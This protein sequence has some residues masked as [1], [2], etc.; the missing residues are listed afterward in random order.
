MRSIEFKSPLLAFTVPGLILVAVAVGLAFFI[1]QAYSVVG[2]VVLGPTLLMLLLAVVGTFL[3]LTGIILH[4]MS[5]LIDSRA[6]RRGG[7]R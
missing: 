4:S 1:I 2:Y 6:E 3:V 5:A 7:S